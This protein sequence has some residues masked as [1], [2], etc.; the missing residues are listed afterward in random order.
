MYSLEH[1][2]TTLRVPSAGQAL[3]TDWDSAMQ[4]SPSQALAFLEA[5]FVTQAGQGVALT[6]DM[7]KELVAFAARIT[8]DESDA[9]TSTLE[10]TD[11]LY[12]LECED[13]FS[14][15]RSRKDRRPG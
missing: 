14:Q 15:A 5:G 1:V 6:D 9:W 4:T 11:L 12:V 13:R 10:L 2:A 7:I 3:C 8:G